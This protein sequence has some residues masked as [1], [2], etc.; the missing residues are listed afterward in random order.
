MKSTLSELDNYDR[1]RYNRQMMLESWGDAGQRRIKNSSVFIAGAG[2]LGS[3]VAM[4]LAAAG[5]GE[6]RICDS[7]TVEPSNLNRQ[8]LHSDSRV[9]QVKAFSAARTLREINPSICVETYPEYLDQDNEERIIGQPSLIVDCLDNYATRYLL[10][11]YCFHHNIPLV[12]AAL[13]GLMGQ[14]TFIHPPE[15]PCLR[16]LFPE[17]PPK[18]VFP[19]LGAT[20]GVLGTLQ[21][22]E[23][24]KYLAGIGETLKGRLLL[25]DGEDMSFTNLCVNRLPDCPV[26][27]G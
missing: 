6:L 12:H 13:W 23:T 3:P 22:M 2:G 1:T 16:C 8:I 20:A 26:C 9:G 7:D 24:L 10:N 17:A 4:Y 21:A 14:L 27:K 5:V 11:E 25:F 19:V 18:S 15:T